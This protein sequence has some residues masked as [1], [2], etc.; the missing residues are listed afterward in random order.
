[1]NKSARDG[2]TAIKH[3]TA[4]AA[5]SAAPDQPP[6]SRRHMSLNASTDMRST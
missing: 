2:G 5:R 4:T 3:K 6:S 1:V